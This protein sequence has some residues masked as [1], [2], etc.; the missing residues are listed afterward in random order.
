MRPLYI[1]ALVVSLVPLVAACL[2]ENFYLGK[3]QNAVEVDDSVAQ[4]DEKD[5]T[6]PVVSKV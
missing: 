1:S 6:T 2:M 4:G 3:T 5:G